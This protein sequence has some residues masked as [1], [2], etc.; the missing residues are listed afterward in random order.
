MNEASKGLCPQC[1]AAYIEPP[2]EILVETGK[3][4]QQC[5]YCFECEGRGCAM[6]DDSIFERQAD[7]V[8]P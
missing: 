7:E 4:C 1:G 8:Q 5:F 3:Y 2:L 6:C